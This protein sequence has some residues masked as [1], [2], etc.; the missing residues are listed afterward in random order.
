M[1][2]TTSERVEDQFVC[3]VKEGRGSIAGAD[4]EESGGGGRSGGC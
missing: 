3:G 2:L 1:H 4:S